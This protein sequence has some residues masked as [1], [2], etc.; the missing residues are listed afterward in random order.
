MM[1]TTSSIAPMVVLP[2][3]GAAETIPVLHALAT[4]LATQVDAP[5]AVPSTTHTPRRTAQPG[6]PAAITEAGAALAPCCAALTASCARSSGRMTRSS[7]G[8]NRAERRAR[9][10]ACKRAWSAYQSQLNVWRETHALD[11]LTESQRASFDDVFGDGIGVDVNARQRVL[12]TQGAAKLAA[13]D[14]AHLDA[15][16]TTLGGA[17]VLSHLRAAHAALSASLGV[18]APLPSG[19]TET[20]PPSDVL[21]VLNEAHAAIRQYVI[22]VYASVTRANP[23]SAT[24]AES[25]LAPL[26]ELAATP[27]ATPRKKSE[28][29]AQPVAPTP[30]VQR[31]ANDTAPALRPTGTG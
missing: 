9:Y 17:R 1:L 2:R 28:T 24:L 18:T 7:G 20:A 16:I 30:V 3:M 12:W 22:V 27:R 23:A 4:A 10:D 19:A 25:L 31:A 11:A 26:L 21:E 14:A 6:V 15:V 29:P 5:T 8:T 13:L